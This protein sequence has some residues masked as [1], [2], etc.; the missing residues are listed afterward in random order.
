MPHPTRY[1]TSVGRTNFSNTLASGF[2][3]QFHELLVKQA[4]EKDSSLAPNMALKLEVMIE[5]YS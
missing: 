2:A 3:P 5:E 1:S 4:Y